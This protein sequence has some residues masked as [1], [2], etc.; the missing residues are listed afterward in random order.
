[1]LQMNGKKLL[2]TILAR[3]PCRTSPCGCRMRCFGVKQSLRTLQL[4]AMLY[5]NSCY[6]ITNI[7]C[8]TSSVWL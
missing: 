1:M 7:A 2:K 4:Q 6:C 5:S 3:L 8:E